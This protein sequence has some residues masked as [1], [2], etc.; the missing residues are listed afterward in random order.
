[1]QRVCSWEAQSE[2]KLEG[3]EKVVEGHAWA[4]EGELGGAQG[5]GKQR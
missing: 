2:D 3:A 1:M 4:R 5:L